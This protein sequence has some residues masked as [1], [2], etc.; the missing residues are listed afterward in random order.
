M[1]QTEARAWIAAA[2]K[3][4]AR[5]CDREG[6][7]AVLDVFDE[8]TKRARLTEGDKRWNEAVD[9]LLNSRFVASESDCTVPFWQAVEGEITLDE[10]RDLI[11]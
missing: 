9:V 10:L 3:Y 5:K 4:G 8:L 1:D 11:L 6:A 2:A 7:Q